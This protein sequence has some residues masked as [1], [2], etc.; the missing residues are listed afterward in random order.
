MCLSSRRGATWH[1][2]AG[3]IQS[4]G[5]VFDT[6]ALEDSGTTRDM[7]QA[8]NEVWIIKT[9]ENFKLENVTRAGEISDFPYETLQV[10]EWIL[11][12]IRL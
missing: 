12:K 2:V 1:D 6:G 7:N 10:N 9:R 3:R 4:A 8:V 11:D 5:L